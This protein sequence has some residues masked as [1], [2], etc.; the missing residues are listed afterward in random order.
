MPT[1]RYQGRTRQGTLAQGEVSASSRQEAVRLMRQKQVLVTRVEE[2]AAKKDAWW[3]ADIQIGTGVHDRDIVVYT[4]QFATMINAG[5]PLVQCLEILSSQSDNPRLRKILQDIQTSVEGG[6][7]YADALRKHPKVFDR[8]YV[9]MVEAGELG[10]LLDTIL[11]RL[12]KH[13]EKAMKL[14]RRIKG[15]MVYPAA[16]LG[17]AVA[18]ITL[19]LVWVIP[20]FAR[21]F[22]EF[23]GALPALTL[24]V[25]ETSDFVQSNILVLLGIL[26]SL[27]VGVR[28]AYKTE[29]GRRI[30]DH[31]LL[32]VPVFGA[33]IRKAAVAQL[34][35]TLGT[36]IGSGVPIL[37]GLDIAGKTS[38]NKVVEE[39]IL[40]A[41]QGIS[42]GKSVADP[43]G[44]SG[45]FP[46]MVTQMIAVGE[47]TGS[48]DAMLGKI[49]DFYEEE[50]DQA[51]ADLTS[52]LEPVMMVFLGVVIGFI[53]IAMYLP[54][55]K[56]A[57]VVG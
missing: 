2:K 14:K 11:D 50:V 17:V 28:Y 39:A 51:V 26:L 13:I 46:K 3:N 1:F 8:L 55:F 43:L 54:I 23:G 49:A 30:L 9:S 15:A 36:L 40:S 21:M 20:V 16:I 57:E 18:V 34:T 5:L 19:L 27:I 7:T 24:F 41:R 56:L 25:I 42:E 53:V 33:L 52:L 29:R 10:G 22:S 6:S 4:R 44:E 37:E 35:R 32:K 12:G 48:L 45:V 47:T 31:F 38:G